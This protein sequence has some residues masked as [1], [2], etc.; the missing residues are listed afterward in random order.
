[1][2][3]ICFQLLVVSRWSLANATKSSPIAN[4]KH[5]SRST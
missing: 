4:R 5:S 2:S 1:M 3:P